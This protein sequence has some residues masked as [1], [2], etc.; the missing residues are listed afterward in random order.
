[1][2]FLDRINESNE[3]DLS[4]FRPLR[5]ARHDLGWVRH[6]IAGRLSD[7]PDVFAVEQQR[8]TLNPKLD[9]F[10]T[11]S[12]AVKS[13]LE[14]LRD[15]G[16]IPAWRDEV[17]PVA[18]TFGV[19]PLLQ[20]ERAAFPCLGLR[21]YG[22]HLNGFVRAGNTIKMWI[23]RRA[24][25]KPTY[26]GM[27]DNM[28]AGGLPIDITLRDNIVKE[29]AEEAGIPADLAQQAVFAGAISYCK[30][31]PEGL[32]PDVQFVC[33]LELPSNFEPRPVD[34]E[35]E[36]FYLW[37]IDKVM[38]VVA[39]T[40]EFKFNCALVIIDFLVR[41]GFVAPGDPDYLEIAQSLR[42]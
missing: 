38:D 13:A 6:D 5:I 3:H 37:P 31:V 28:V 39:N 19:A 1:M 16:A 17:Y 41:R 34:G 11:R 23:A 8:V 26:P 29:C 24:R 33:D 2:S 30:E 40:T 32:K 25:D 14:A 7:Y 4:R 36:A 12:G 42:R 10:E 15:S 35:V 9:S 18:P 21:A 22:V 20:M 27:F